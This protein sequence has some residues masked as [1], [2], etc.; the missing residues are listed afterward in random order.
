[1]LTCVLDKNTIGEGR[2]R[3]GQLS[4]EGTLDRRGLIVL[5]QNIML[6]TSMSWGFTDPHVHGFSQSVFCFGLERLNRGASQ[7][8]GAPLS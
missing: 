1:M 4:G 3:G 8:L 5:K 2:Y 6:R 7:S